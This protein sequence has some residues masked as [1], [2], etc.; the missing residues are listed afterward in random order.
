MRRLV[1]L[2]LDARQ[3]SEIMRLLDEAGIPYKETRSPF[4]LLSADA[5]WVADE[6]Y[7]RACAIIEDEAKA[8]A[9]EARAQWNAEWAAEHKGSYLRWLWSRVRQ[10][11]FAGLVTA[12]FLIALVCVMLFYPLA[13][14]F[15]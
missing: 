3:E 9:E 1:G 13:L 15:R 4:R 7:Q 12:L 14:V 2:P 6:D 11:S 10:A 8:Y 5:I